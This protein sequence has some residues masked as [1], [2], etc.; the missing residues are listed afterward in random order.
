MRLTGWLETEA[1]AIVTAALDPLCAPGKLAPADPAN[2]D[3]TAGQRRADALT[4]ICRYALAG[5]ELPDNGGDRPQIVVTMNFDDLATATGAGM[6]DTG[7]MLAPE[8]VRRLACDAALLPACWVGKGRCW[9]SGGNDA[10][11]PDP[12]GGPWSYETADA[13]SPA[14]T[15]R[16]AGATGTTSNTG[17]TAALRP[18]TMRHCCVATTTGSSTET[19]GKSASPPTDS[20]NSSH[21][22]TSTGNKHPA[23]TPTTE[24]PEGPSRVTVS[25]HGFAGFEDMRGDSLGMQ[26]LMCRLPGNNLPCPQSQPLLGRVDCYAA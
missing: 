16:P 3:R 18:W 12:C 26:Q 11:S 7:G 24:D 15:A 4:E 22:P 5:G 21:P 9:M 8:A 17:P 13:P 20:P 10:C 23:E 14:A 1:A 6:L 25:L 2:D 19:T